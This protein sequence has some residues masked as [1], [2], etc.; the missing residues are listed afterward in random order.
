MRLLDAPVQ[1][2]CTAGR[3]LAAFLW[4]G[5]WFSV[6]ERVDVWREVG[7]WWDGEAEKTFLVVR[8]EPPGLFE[9]CCTAGSPPAW[10]LYKVYD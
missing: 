7:A 3:R 2:R 4:R 6:K 10:R 8:T 1:V 9:L 5:R